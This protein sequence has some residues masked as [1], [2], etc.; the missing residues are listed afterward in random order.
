MT[1]VEERIERLKR[2]EKMYKGIAKAIAEKLRRIA[3]SLGKLEGGEEEGEIKCMSL[4]EDA[5]KIEEQNPAE[6]VRLAQYEDLCKGTANVEEVRRFLKPNLT[7]VLKTFVDRLNSEEIGKQTQVLKRIVPCI[8]KRVKWVLLHDIALHAQNPELLVLHADTLLEDG[9]AG[10]P[11]EIGKAI[12]SV[13]MHYLGV[14]HEEQ[15]SLSKIGL[16]RRKFLEGGKG[17]AEEDLKKEVNRLV[18]EYEMYEVFQEYEMDPAVFDSVAAIRIY[19]NHLDWSWTYNH[20]I[21]EVIC[22]R[23]KRGSEYMIY[24]LGILYIE[25][26]RVIGPHPSL[27]SVLKILD[28]VVGIGRGEV[29]GPSEF[30]LSEQLSSLIVLR[31]FR[32]GIAIKWQKQKM[33]EVSSEEQER[34]RR[35][36]RLRVY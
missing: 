34:I 25:W 29:I 23:I 36:W 19:S 4:Y 31:Q 12:Q 1:D 15:G 11:G 3:R 33:E 28:K 10:I 22:P 26:S 27:D 24:V 14:E 7:L 30:T 2:S 13:V 20:L 17:P 5:N 21:R 32:P 9:F 8:S 18:Q 35:I 6:K 16:L